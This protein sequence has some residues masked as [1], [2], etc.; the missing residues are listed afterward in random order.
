M[1]VSKESNGIDQNET[2]WA[3]AHEVRRAAVNSAAVNR[4]AVNDDTKWPRRRGWTG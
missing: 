1:N 4:V 2:T 3:Y